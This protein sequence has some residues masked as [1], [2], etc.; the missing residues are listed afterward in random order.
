M[1]YSVLGKTG[2]TVSRIGFGGAALGNMYTPSSDEEAE[3]TLYEAVEEYGINLIDTGPSYG[4]GSQSEARL[5]KMFAGDP[6]FRRKVIL[7]TKCGDYYATPDESGYRRDMSAE[8]ILKRFPEQL[9]RL[10]TDYVDLLQLHDAWP[11]GEKLILEESLPAILELKRKGY[12]RAVGITG[13]SMRFA[14]RILEQTDE[15][16]SILTFGN[17]NLMNQTIGKIVPLCAEKNVGLMNCSVLFMGVLTERAL[18]DPNRVAKGPIRN[19]P[20]FLPAMRKAV[21]LCRSRGVDIGDLAVQFGCDC[22]FCQ[23]TILSM[24]RR[25]RLRHNMALLEKPYDQ[26]LAAAVYAILKDHPTDFFE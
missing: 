13:T 6:G 26:E 20:D 22:A 7:A 21:D 4:F 3:A 2:L 18:T 15:L 8:G 25:E 12:A 10:H 5:G 23:S 24:G 19:T 14:R 17:Y 16:D 11:S 9:E 1:E